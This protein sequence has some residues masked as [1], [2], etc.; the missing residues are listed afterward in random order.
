MGV[1]EELMEEPRTIADLRPKMRLEGVVRETQLYGAVVDIGLEYDGMVHISQLSAERVNRVADVVQPGDSVI[2]WVTE[3]S[4]QK[5]RIGLT[6][7]EPPQ[8]GWRELTEGQ[9]YTG[10]VTRLE[11]YGAF[12]DIGAGRAG[13][14]HVREMSA[15]YV[16]DPSELVKIGEEVEVRI[17]KVDRRRR[18]IDLTMMGIADQQIIEEDAEEGEVDNRTAMEIALQQAQ[19]QRAPGRRHGKRRSP[20]PDLSERED[21]LARTLE[22]HSKR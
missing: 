7:V 1:T 18:R 9:I 16:R 14:L 19:A 17:L 8:V 13:L 21:I 3:V 10:T 6:M 20:D 11:R 5:G 22:Q 12:V 15:G 4:T 2:V